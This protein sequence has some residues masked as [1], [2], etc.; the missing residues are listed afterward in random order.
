MCGT[1]FHIFNSPATPTTRDGNTFIDMFD[2]KLHSG[3]WFPCLRNVLIQLPR[4][5][6]IFVGASL[7]WH[8]IIAMAHE[9]IEKGLATLS[10]GGISMPKRK[11]PSTQ[12]K[13]DEALTIPRPHDLS[14]INHHLRESIS[15]ALKKY[16][17]ILA[18]QARWAAA[19]V[20]LISSKR[21]VGERKCPRLHPY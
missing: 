15:D 17:W 20:L 16:P 3:P 9:V 7:P 11:C 8:A 2:I 1:S 19:V 18:A 5:L 14:N 10:S 21:S 13:E 12:C 6:G 4:V